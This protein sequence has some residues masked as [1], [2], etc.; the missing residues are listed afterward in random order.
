LSELPK[1]LELLER[2]VRFE[3]EDLTQILFNPTPGL[4]TDPDVHPETE[5]K[6][7]VEGIVL[8]YQRKRREDILDQA[9][10]MFMAASSDWHET[11]QVEWTISPVAPAPSPN[12]SAMDRPPVPTTNGTN[13]VSIKVKIEQVDDEG[14]GFDG[15]DDGTD[16]EGTPPDEGAKELQSENES[17]PFTD[18]EA[19]TADEVDDDAWGWNDQDSEP[20]YPL[21]PEGPHGPKENG[22]GSAA[23]GEPLWDAWDDTPPSPPTKKIVPRPATKL[24][25]FSNKAN[26]GTRPPNIVV[27]HPGPE[28]VP[29]NM[30]TRANKNPMPALA[31]KTSLSSSWSSSSG[32]PN[33]QFQSIPPTPAPITPHQNAPKEFYSFQVVCRIFSSWWRASCLNLPNFHDRLC[34]LL[35]FPP[36]IPLR[37]LRQCL[38]V[39]LGQSS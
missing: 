12:G 35:I 1:Y 13:P 24:E 10:R 6:N 30:P 4:S 14:W 8:H 3:H 16:G 28:R 11:F 26:Q 33:Q 29:S 21:G 23:G 22:N 37:L 2:A 15:D 32:S 19:S 36:R 34:S 17:S 18:P 7:W 9:R 5:I 20:V 27:P 39:P 31:S 38:G 25:K